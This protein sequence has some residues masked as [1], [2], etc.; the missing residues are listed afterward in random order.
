L[1]VEHLD[2]AGGYLHVVNGKG[3]KLRTSIL[4]KPILMTPEAHLRDT[5]SRAEIRGN[6]DQANPETA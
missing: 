6:L 4:P 1:K 5:F 2:S 3:G